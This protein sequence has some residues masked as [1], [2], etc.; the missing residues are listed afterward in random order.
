MSHSARAKACLLALLCAA[1]HVTAEVLAEVC[2]EEADEAS[3]LMLPGKAQA[4]LVEP[5]NRFKSRRAA[6]LAYEASVDEVIEEAFKNVSDLG[7]AITPQRQLDTWLDCS[8]YNF[9]EFREE[10]GGQDHAWKE[11]LSRDLGCDSVN[12][13]DSTCLALYAFWEASL[14]LSYKFPEGPRFANYLVTN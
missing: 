11:A 12:K 6:L 9:S 1:S 13:D 8:Q 10:D 3:C 5:A 2:A 4:A 7:T 14:T